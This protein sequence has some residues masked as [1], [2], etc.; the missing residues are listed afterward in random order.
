[1]IRQDRFLNCTD[2]L[3]QRVSKPKNFENAVRIFASQVTIGSAGQRRL[4]A[5][6]AFL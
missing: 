4:S 1:M 6:S 3:T 5:D 2:F